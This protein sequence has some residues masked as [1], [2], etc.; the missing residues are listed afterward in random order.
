LSVSKDSKL[1]APVAESSSDISAPTVSTSAYANDPVELPAQAA[2]S[3]PDSLLKKPPAS[4]LMVPDSPLVVSNPADP[5]LLAPTL[6]VSPS[7]PVISGPVLLLPISPST[8]TVPFLLFCFFVFAHVCLVLGIVC[9]TLHS[10]WAKIRENVLQDNA[11]AAVRATPSVSNDVVSTSDAIGDKGGVGGTSCDDAPTICSATASTSSTI[12]SGHA[13]PTATGKSEEEDSDDDFGMDDDDDEGQGSAPAVRLTPSSL[14]AEPPS[15]HSGSTAPTGVPAIASLVPVGKSPS[16]PFVPTAPASTPSTTATDLLLDPALQSDPA[17]VPGPA[18]DPAVGQVPESSLVAS[19]ND[20]PAIHSTAALTHSTI[21]NGLVSSTATG[22]SKEE[23]DDDVNDDNADTVAA[24]GP[25][26]PT[27]TIHV[28]DDEVSHVEVTGVVESSNGVP[29]VVWQHLSYFDM[30][31]MSIEAYTD[32]N[33]QVLDSKRAVQW[34]ISTMGMQTMDPI[35]EMASR[36]TDPITN[37]RRSGHTFCTH[38]KYRNVQYRLPGFATRQEAFFAKHLFDTYIFQNP[39]RL[40][41][42]KPL[43][44]RPRVTIAHYGRIDLGT[45]TDGKVSQQMKY[46]HA[47]CLARLKA[48]QHPNS[49]SLIAYVSGKIAEIYDESP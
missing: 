7:A 34:V 48:P 32:E 23:D 12:I 4:A 2:E 40:L 25:V 42:S 49:M 24:A 47:R 35:R 19:F 30:E 26:A 14:N 5:K 10:T 38:W 3:P 21:I 43:P 16:V 33:E 13:P 1:F 37:V 15:I 41:Q 39:R 27:V 46:A 9:L 28:Q 31:T 17:V 44:G 29:N 6:P 8:P 22:E 45:F 20:A 18:M 11:A 36:F